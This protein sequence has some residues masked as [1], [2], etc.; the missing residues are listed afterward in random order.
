MLNYMV[1]IKNIS[2]SSVELDSVEVK[3]WLVELDTIRKYSGFI[4]PNFILSHPKAVDSQFLILLDNNHLTPK[5]SVY[6]AAQFVI[7]KDPDLAVICQS[8]AYGHEKS[9]VLFNNKKEWSAYDMHL[10]CL[11]FKNKK[12]EEKEKDDD[13]DP[14]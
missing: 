3:Y 4:V 6:E 9:W 8:I 10:N 13:K 2:K 7:Y 11:P 5:S 14:D 1:D 12:D